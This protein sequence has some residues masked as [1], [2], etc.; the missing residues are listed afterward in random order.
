YRTPDFGMW[1]RGSKYNNGSNELHASSIGMA[2]AALEAIN[3]FNLFGEQGAAWSVI[4]VDI[5]AHN[6]NRTIFDTLLPRE[7][8]SKHTD[9]SLIPTISWPCFS[10]HEEALKHQTLDK[11]HRKLKGKYGYKRFLRDGYKT[12]HED[13]NRKYYRPAEI[14]MF[15]CI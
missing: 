10:I 3:G 1:E 8:A 11:A 12:V 13:K 9:A 14:K 7:S 6:R 2:K 5:D 4:Y 15:D